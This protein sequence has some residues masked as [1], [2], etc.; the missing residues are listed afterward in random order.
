LPSSDHLARYTLHEGRD[1]D[2]VAGLYG[3]TRRTLMAKHVMPWL[4]A[5]QI[6]ARGAKNALV[7]HPLPI[8]QR[9]MYEVVTG[10]AAGTQA[11]WPAAVITHLQDIYCDPALM[12]GDAA[13]PDDTQW[14]AR[15][16]AT[17]TQSTELRRHGLPVL[18]LALMLGV[19][20]DDIRELVKPQQRTGGF[21][22]PRYLQYAD[23]AKNKVKAIG[24]PHGRCRG[25][26][27]ADHVVLLPEVAASGFGVICTTCRRAPNTGVAWDLLQFPREYL[28]HWTNAG[29]GGGLRVTRQ[30]IPA[31][32]PLPLLVSVP[33]PVAA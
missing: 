1:L 31:A 29:A 4:V 2:R 5:H 26:Q 21:T 25:R 32:N 14:I 15:A 24:C 23:K 9:L 7:D 19:T 8:V 12:W 30:S 18:D 27:H 17:V 33:N 10:I 22:R 11:P 13:C 3:C 16:V 28:G 6:T 20:E